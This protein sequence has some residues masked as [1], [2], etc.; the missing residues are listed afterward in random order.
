ME[1]QK[2][3]APC[4]FSLALPT[5][6]VLSYLVQAPPRLRHSVGSHE[7]APCIHGRTR[8]CR[9]ES[10]WQ[11]AKETCIACNAARTKQGLMSF[12]CN[13]AGSFPRLLSRRVA[14]TLGRRRQRQVLYRLQALHAATL[15]IALILVLQ[16]ARERIQRGR[17]L[18]G[19]K[20]VRQACLPKGVQCCEPSA[21]IKNISRDMR[22]QVYRA[23]MH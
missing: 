1:W 12:C 7:S 4:S 14:G 8:G 15:S 5:C 3:L 19:H 17:P 20:P 6:V 2:P 11:H 23:R 22:G 13:P 16:V 18:A 21:T 10:G 9:A